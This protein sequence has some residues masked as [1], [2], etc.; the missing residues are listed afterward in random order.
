MF[1]PRPKQKKVI[2]FTQG[3]MGVAAVPGSGKTQTLSFL[4]ARL[5][6]E[7]CIEEGQEILVVTLTNSAAGNFQSRIDGFIH[8]YGMIKGI[9]YRVRTLHGLAHD[10]VRE[11]PDLVGLP[12]QFNIIDER[13][14]GLMLESSVRDWLINNP[15]VENRY[16]LPDQRMNNQKKWIDTIIDCCV[17]FIRTAKDLQLDAFELS[18]RLAALDVEPVLLRMGCDVYA[19][20]ARKL[21]LREGVD[22]DDLIRFALVALRTDLEYLKRLRSRWPYILEDEAQDSS[23]LQQ[24][25]LELLSGDRGNW[26]RVGDPNQAIFETFTTADP[27][28][29]TDFIARADVVEAPLTNAG[30]SSKKIMA[31]ANHLVAWTVHEHPIE[32]LRDALYEAYIEEPPPGDPQP[33]PPDEESDIH[34]FPPIKQLNSEQE[35]HA[36]L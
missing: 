4:A 21:S 13:E 36:V 26:V 10:I 17:A 25:I 7:G 16:F 19:D 6:H 3:K 35:L 2:D 1:N 20:Y 5:I 27:K 34:I 11:R 18:G 24:E 9:G 22:F 30:R 23:H 32:E 8:N 28:L 14:S 15:E 12:S 33:N 31:L 29:L